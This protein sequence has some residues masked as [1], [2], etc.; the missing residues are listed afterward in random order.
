MAGGTPRQ[1]RAAV[2]GLAAF[3]ALIL[4]LFVKLSFGT[5]ASHEGDPNWVSYCTARWEP[6]RLSAQLA[7]A[8]GVGDA[9]GQGGAHGH[10]DRL[11]A[12]Q[13]SHKVLDLAAMDHG[14][15]MGD[16]G[17]H[18]HA[19]HGGGGGKVKASPH[20][21]SFR[22]HIVPGI[23]FIFLSTWYGIAMIRL[24]L[25]AKRHR[26]L[27]VSLA[28]PYFLTWGD[29]WV[30][31]RFQ[32][33][34]IW[35]RIGLI[36][37]GL[38]A[39]VY[40]HAPDNICWHALYNRDGYFDMDTVNVWMHTMMYSGF[41]LAALVDY[42]TYREL[43]PAGLGVVTHL[44]QFANTGLM[45]AMHLGGSPTNWLVHALLFGCF[46]FYVV[47]AALDFAVQ[48]SHTLSLMRPFVLFLIATWF[49]QIGYTSF[50]VPGTHPRPAPP[51]DH[52]SPVTEM[53]V[54]L[55]F[56]KHLLG[57]LGGWCLLLILSNAVPDRFRV[58]EEHEKRYLVGGPP[59]QK[60]TLWQS[61][62]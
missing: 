38:F 7:A 43:L 10:A 59:E 24:W 61:S 32:L 26:N 53:A 13:Q 14:A 57:G 15:A 16:D 6:A 18:D 42:A 33:G 9:S 56:S 45:F 40:W 29:N 21:G 39:E 19:G 28:Q 50:G 8:G 22:G 34:E 54:P 20:G 11:R 41:M 37:L 17:A 47:I 44:L 36:G 3:V 46:V 55:V 62:P 30:G 27:K 1:A 4:F 52:G 23:M 60:G 31:R 2:A 25:I 48:T 35:F 49:V 5:A 58:L 12:L 51:W